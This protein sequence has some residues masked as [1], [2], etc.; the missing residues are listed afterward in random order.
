VPSFRTLL[1]ALWHDRLGL[2]MPY[3]GNATAALFLQTCAPRVTRELCMLMLKRQGLDG[4]V[5]R[6][7]GAQCDAD[8]VPHSHIPHRRK[9][10]IFDRCHPHRLLMTPLQ[11][12]RLPRCR[13]CLWAR[14]GCLR[15]LPL[16]LRCGKCVRLHPTCVARS[17]SSSATPPLPRPPRCL[18][19]WRSPCA[20]P[21]TEAATAGCMR[22]CRRWRWR[23]RCDGLASGL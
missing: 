15:G 14:A 19:G 21:V 1:D 3:A 10:C 22:S 12:C 17:T 5:F 16:L 4:S 20:L 23:W 8:R 6:V 9:W 7:V 13:W 11:S 18:C 2:E